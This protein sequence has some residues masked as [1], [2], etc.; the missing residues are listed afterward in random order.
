MDMSICKDSYSL[1]PSLFQPFVARSLALLSLY[2]Q[3]FYVQRFLRSGLLTFKG[4]YVQ[5]AFVLGF[6]NTFTDSY[7]HRFLR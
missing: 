3:G 5:G 4:F 2:V 1:S 6:F 7:V